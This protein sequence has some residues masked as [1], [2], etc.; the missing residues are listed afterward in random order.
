MFVNVPIAALCLV[1]GLVLLREV[2]I[3]TTARFDY[4][5]TALLVIALTALV[6]ALIDAPSSAIPGSAR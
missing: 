6:Y 3:V 4:A 1:L 2:R 5:G